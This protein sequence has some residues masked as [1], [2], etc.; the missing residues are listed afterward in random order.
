MES[1]GVTSLLVLVF[2]LFSLLISS[3]SISLFLVSKLLWHFVGLPLLVYHDRESWCWNKTGCVGFSFMDAR[4][5][6]PWNDLRTIGLVR[7][8]VYDLLP[9]IKRNISACLLQQKL[10]LISSNQEQFQIA[11][12]VQGNITYPVRKLLVF[13]GMTLF[14]RDQVW[15]LGFCLREGFIDYTASWITIQ[16]IGDHF[17]ILNSVEKI[18]DRW[19]LGQQEVEALC[20]CCVFLLSLLYK[21]KAQSQNI[22][23]S[24]ILWLLDSRIWEIRRSAPPKLLTRWSR[25]KKFFYENS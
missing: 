22:V 23:E 3:V 2:F 25:L 9:W 8:N 4:D 16:N 1:C 15:I 7:Y 12:L 20:V 14:I 13:G 24:K 5:F 10:H 6:F 18:N 19:R 11:F 21:E 17:P